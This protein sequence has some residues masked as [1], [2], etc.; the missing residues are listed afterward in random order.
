MKKYLI[1]ANG[2]FLSADIIKELADGAT[3]IAL[4]GASDKLAKLG[5]MPHIILGDFD[6]VELNNVW[7]AHR[8]DKIDDH[9]PP[10]A[11][12]FGVTIVPAKNQ[13]KTD[14]VKAINYC[15]ENKATHIAVVCATGNRMDHT[16]GNIRMLRA[17]YKKERALEIFTETQMLTYAKDE[18]VTMIGEQGDYCGIMSFP[19]AS[20]KSEGLMWG[21]ETD[22]QLKF[23][24]SDSTCNLIDKS[25]AKITITGEA[26]LIHPGSLAAQKQLKE[27]EKSV[28]KSDFYRK[29][30]EVC[31]AL[32]F[33]L[34]TFNSKDL[35]DIKQIRQYIKSKLNISKTE[36]PCHTIHYLSQKKENVYKEGNASGV[37][38]S[39]SPEKL[40][41][42]SYFDK[43]KNRNLNNL[44]REELLDGLPE[45]Y[46]KRILK[47]S[48]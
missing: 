24:Y 22:Y 5:I 11:G 6:S 35:Q 7:G 34:K 23:G 14:L 29:M 3:I 17:E 39:L 27:A 8:F 9:T 16:L 44:T 26:L 46:K 12:N 33:H 30:M 15:D 43:F 37:L 25:P 36:K 4:D 40:S 42:Y 32:E 1:V 13:D 38:V 47:A 18:T 21:G 19:E 2:P 10:Y 31:I 48:I 28:G 20:F 41:T 45:Q